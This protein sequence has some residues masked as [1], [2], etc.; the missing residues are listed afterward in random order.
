[1]SKDLSTGGIKIVSDDFM[2]P[3]SDVNVNINF[4]DKIVNSKTTVAWC[5]KEKF[6]ERYATGLSFTEI[7]TTDQKYISNFLTNIYPS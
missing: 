4:I 7:S 6:G 1:V 2:T 3:G 5:N